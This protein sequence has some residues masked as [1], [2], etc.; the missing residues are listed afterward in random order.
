MKT[1]K[2]E[3]TGWKRFNRTPWGYYLLIAVAAWACIIFGMF[4]GLVA[5][6]RLAQAA[7]VS[8]QLNEQETPITVA[9]EAPVEF[10]AVLERVDVRPVLPAAPA[11]IQEPAQSAPAYSEEELEILALIIYQEAG[12]DACSNETRQMVG[13]VFLNRVANPIYQGTFRQVATAEAQ[14]GRLYWTGLVW[15]ER[16]Q[17]P[18][19]AHAVERAYNTAKTLLAGTVERLLPTDVIFQSE[20][21]QGTEIIAERDGLYFCR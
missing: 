18:Q 3:C 21:V 11:E 16:A 7:P 17:L 1:K 12:G 8:A 19:E 5:A 15:P 13:E 20:F 14:Y 10:L 4:M 2:R 9:P 6:D